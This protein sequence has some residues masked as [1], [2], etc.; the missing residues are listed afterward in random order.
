MNYLS[1]RW[2]ARWVDTMSIHWWF[3]FQCISQRKKEGKNFYL[4]PINMADVKISISISCQS[5]PP[6]I[7]L[8]VDESKTFIFSS[9]KD[10]NFLTTRMCTFL[11]NHNFQ[12]YVKGIMVSISRKYLKDTL[13][14]CVTPWILKHQK[15]NEQCHFAFYTFCS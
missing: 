4:S 10:S 14:N 6:F 3:W 12:Q 2:K 8:L 5:K 7:L 13:N 15:E 11:H 9:L 1:F